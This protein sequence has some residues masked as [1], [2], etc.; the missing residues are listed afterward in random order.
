[1]AVTRLPF[2]IRRVE[3]RSFALPWSFG[4][5]FLLAYF[6]IFPMVARVDATL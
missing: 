1:M 6:E 3:R 5:A 4:P 2:L